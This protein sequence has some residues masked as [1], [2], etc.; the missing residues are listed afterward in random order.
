MFVFFSVIRILVREHPSRRPSRFRGL[1]TACET[2]S[3]N[4]T[5]S[6][7][8]PGQLTRDARRLQTPASSGSRVI[9]CAQPATFTLS[10]QWPHVRSW[11]G[12][13]CL[14]H[15]ARLS[16]AYIGSFARRNNGRSHCEGD[17]KAHRL[18]L[19]L[20]PPDDPAGGFGAST[21]PQ[22]PQASGSC[23]VPGQARRRRS[24]CFQSTGNH[25][26][27]QSL[28]YF[29]PDSRFTSRY[30]YSPPS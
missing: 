23:S 3:L 29:P 4:V 30:R 25:H 17:C 8:A 9:S 1:S 22:A 20:H 5:R 18:R 6:A 7:G 27:N 14:R 21:R 28:A 24:L 10:C 19:H 15:Q 13:C 16:I 11:H 26:C 2:A 12:R